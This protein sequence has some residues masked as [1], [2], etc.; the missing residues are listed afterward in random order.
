MSVDTIYAAILS[1]EPFV[2]LI[3]VCETPLYPH[4]NPTLTLGFNWL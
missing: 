1:L 2:I 4:L 3:I